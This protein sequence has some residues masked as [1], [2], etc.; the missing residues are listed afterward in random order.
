MYAGFNAAGP[1]VK[2]GG[3]LTDHANPANFEIEFESEISGFGHANLARSYAFEINVRPSASD[4][5]NIG[6]KAAINFPTD[7]D[8]AVLS[9]APISTA[10]GALVGLSEFGSPLKDVD[11]SLVS[12][13]GDTNNGMYTIGGPNGDQLLV[14]TSLAGLNDIVHSVRVLAEGNSSVEKAITFTIKLDSDADGLIDA[15]ETTFGVLGDFATGADH[16]ADGLNDDVEF[17][18][19][20]NPNNPDA[21]NDGS[22][23]GA[24]IANGTDP[25]KPDTDGDGLNDGA[26]A[27][28]KSNPLV[29]DTDG[30]GISDGAEVSSANGFVTDPTLRD[31]DGDGFDDDIELAANSD[32]TNAGSQPSFEGLVTIGV[33]TDLPA[34]GGVDSAGTRMNIEN[35][36]ESFPT[37]PPGTYNVRD[38]TY[39]AGADTE[40]LQPFLATNVSGDEYIVIWVGPS[41]PASG[42]D[43]VTTVPYEIGSQQFTLTAA[44]EVY[45]GFNAAGP[46]VKFGNGGL[47]D[48]NNPAV[49]EIDVDTEIAAWTNANLG[50]SYRFGINVESAVTVD[51]EITKVV[52][53]GGVSPSVTLTF[54]STPGATYALFT[55]TTLLPDGEPGGWIEVTDGIDSEGTETTYTDTDGVEF[56]TEVYYRFGETR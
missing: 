7:A 41:E 5:E 18:L 26:E 52:Y 34:D 3:G 30:D 36:D 51:F 4:V 54:N 38:F 33:G 45:A 46:S 28:A 2:F 19:K 37:L 49:F 6:I 21:D 32:P 1:I 47:T 43:D 14:N 35:S 10:V 13:E 20:F 9:S 22:L 16:D 44:T 31:T 53:S 39:V 15:W 23:D 27:T 12:G 29:S 50:R 56:A 55:S 8:A 17:G 11:F 40:D 42:S 24:E 48:H 25:A